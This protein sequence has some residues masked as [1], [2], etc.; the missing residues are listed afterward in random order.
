MLSSQVLRLV[1][2]R[3]LSTSAC[4]QGHSS[5]AIPSYTLPTYHDNRGT[6]LPDVPFVGQLT[7]EQVA[8]K[9]KE[10]GSWKSLSDKEKLEL[11]YI[12]FNNTFADMNKGSNEWKTVLGGTLIFIGLSAILIMWQRKFVFGEVPHTLSEDWVAMQT[13]RMLDMRVNPVEG[14]S[15]KWDYDKNEWKK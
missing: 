5:V 10:K 3:A 15:S 1:G 2:R 13:K 12:K 7:S 9:E 6:P 14:L 8:L 4:L 11:Y